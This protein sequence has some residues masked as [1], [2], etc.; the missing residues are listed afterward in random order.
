MIVIKKAYIYTNLS[1]VKIMYIFQHTKYVI[2]KF[3]HDNTEPEAHMYQ[4]Y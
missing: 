2:T 4:P 3:I 1:C